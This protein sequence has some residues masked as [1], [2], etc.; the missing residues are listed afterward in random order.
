[1]SIASPSC[2]TCFHSNNQFKVIFSVF[3]MALF[4]RLVYLLL[5]LK[6]MEIAK[7]ILTLISIGER[8]TAKVF[9]STQIIKIYS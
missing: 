3:G 7:N 8:V 1:M 4:Q 6:A 5:K 9:I 2:L